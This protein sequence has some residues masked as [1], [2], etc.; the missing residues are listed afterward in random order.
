MLSNIIF[1][2]HVSPSYNRGINKQQN[3]Q[4]TAVTRED[5]MRTEV[6][7]SAL[8]GW[9]VT[10]THIHGLPVALVPG[11][12]NQ[13]PHISLVSTHWNC[14]RQ[15]VSHLGCYTFS[16]F[17]C[18]AWESR[19]IMINNSG[20]SCGLI[21]DRGRIGEDQFLF[22][23]LHVSFLLWF[24]WISRSQRQISLS[25]RAQA[26]ISIWKCLISILCWGRRPRLLFTSQLS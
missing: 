21:K 7:S 12:G 5:W 8:M 6:Q 22:S 2:F 19:L 18:L 10:C 1:S 15:S 17:L 11:H 3:G 26:P 14:Q 9:G 23:A 13:H 24:P 25:G 20:E 4:W 16:S